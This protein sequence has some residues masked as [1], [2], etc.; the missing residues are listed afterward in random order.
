MLGGTVLFFFLVLG[1]YS[2]GWEGIS[3]FF[4]HFGRR[5]FSILDFGG[6]GENFLFFFFF[7]L[8]IV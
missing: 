1:G 2:R 5:D 7:F 8:G 4:G 3:P 6:I